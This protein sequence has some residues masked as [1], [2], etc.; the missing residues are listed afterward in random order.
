MKLPLLSGELKR[1]ASAWM[2]LVAVITV[3]YLAAP[4]PP[5]MVLAIAIPA[6]VSPDGAAAAPNRSQP[7]DEGIDWSKVPS[8]SDVGPNAVAAF[9]N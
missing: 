7:L 5:D 8:D 4:P 2:L 6:V 9:D 1:K 3:A